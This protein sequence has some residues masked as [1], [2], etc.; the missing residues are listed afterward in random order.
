MAKTINISSIGAEP[1]ENPNI[2]ADTN[3]GNDIEKLDFSSRYTDPNGSGIR[4]YTGTDGANTFQAE[5]LLN[6]KPE[7]IAKHT[8]DDGK[9]DWRGV[10][11][12]NNNYH[13]HWV[14]GPGEIVIENFGEGDKFILR[15]HT[16]EAI[17]LEES[18]GVATIGLVSDQGRDNSRGNGAHDLDVLGKATIYH[19]GSFNFWQDVKDITNGVFD[20]V[21]ITQVQ[22][23]VVETPAKEAQK[24]DTTYVEDV[25]QTAEDTTVEISS[26]GAE[27]LENPNIPA[28]TND[29]NDIEKLDFSSRYTDPNG[30]GIRT[31]TGTDGANTFQAEALLNAK[32]EII[33]KH[34]GDDGKIDWRGVAGENNNYHDHWVEGPGE[35]VIENFGEGDKFILRGHT[36][37]AILLE[38]SE[39]VATIGL[40]S[41]QG[42]DN[43]RG[44]GA[45]DLDVLGKATIYHDGSFNFGQDVKDITNG[46]FD[47]VSEFA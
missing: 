45:H 3:D 28:D 5:A 23:T 30:S 1:L 13:D 22:Q 20:G 21:D 39:G 2:P 7:I 38:E 17:L 40:V 27:P 18:E 36:S 25:K 41:D 26:T 16:S 9:I 29:G 37:E 19:D 31:Y 10:A 47:G 4:T 44:N 14:E 8:G 6:A 32:P 33:A 11:G 12:E 43:S 15:G 42:R 34:T 24:E 35:I 46:V